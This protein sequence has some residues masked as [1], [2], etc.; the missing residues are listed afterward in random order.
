MAYIAQYT[1]ARYRYA[2]KSAPLYGVVV[3][4]FLVFIAGRSSTATIS[5]SRSAA[6]ATAGVGAVLVTVV[7]V[8]VASHGC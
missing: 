1:T 4:Q 5:R 8:K 2:S 7:A 6:A 3:S